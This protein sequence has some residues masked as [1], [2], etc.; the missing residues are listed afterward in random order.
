MATLSVGTDLTVAELI[1][2]QEPDGS[3]AQMI[4]MLTQ[5][6]RILEDITWIECNNGT[7]Y[8]GTRTVAEPTGQER[9]YDEGV[10]KE[11][12]RTEKVLEPTC[13]LN[14]ISEVDAKKLKHHT[15]RGATEEQA[16]L[17]ED[18]F[19][20]KG[21]TKTFVSRL[22]DGSVTDD[23]RRINGINS[24]SDYNTL[25]TAGSETRVFDNAG[26]NCADASI[27]TSIYIV[28]WGD[29]KVD[30]IY[31]VNDP[32]SGNKNLPIGMEDF[33][34]SIINQSG[35]SETK[36]YPAWQ[37]WFDLSFGLMIHDP[38]CIKRIA[39]IAVGH[40][41]DG[42][43]YFSFDENVLSD[44]VAELE[45]GGAGAVIYANKA[46]FKQMQRR[47]NDKGN[48]WFTQES[49]G[50]G[51]FARPVLRYQGIQIKRVDQIA[52][53]QADVTT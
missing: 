40:A 30:C 52:N 28:Q 8:E 20:L 7:Y 31:P 12:G 26:G 49:E 43:N 21:M 9:G 16:R 1:R 13:M 19:F 39:N 22:F 32:Q 37:T 25:Q 2:R 53:T 38:R 50:E 5:E 34:K 44:A 14:G 17:N 15:A 33:G 51:P 48:A 35:T 36:K 29:R 24:R 4:D 41:D 10:T 45:Y 46:I 3:M 23:P 18:M 42:T 27:F 11:A 47:A 6:N